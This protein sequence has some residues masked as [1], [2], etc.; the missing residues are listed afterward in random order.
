M[1]T[2]TKYLSQE[3]IQAKLPLSSTKRVLEDLS[4]LL[5]VALVEDQHPADTIFDR[6]L[7]REK[8]GST[9]INAGVAIPRA[10]YDSISDP[11]LAVIT[12]EEGIDFGAEDK[13][14]VDI[15]V[16][17][18]VPA[19]EDQQSQA[20]LLLGGLTTILKNPKFCHKVREAKDNKA[21]YNAFF[22]EAVIG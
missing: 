6:L 17:F 19:H 15:F 13:Q 7:K 9:S 4:Q 18:L 5:A 22:L 11:I 16:G 14:P 12:L 2:I 20:E 10:K 8:L 21:L 1:L 3:H